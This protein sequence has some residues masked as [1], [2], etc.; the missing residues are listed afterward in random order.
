MTDADLL[1]RLFLNDMLDSVLDE[2][3]FELPEGQMRMVRDRD[4]ML[5]DFLE[6]SSKLGRALDRY[7][8]Q[9]YPAEL[10]ELRAERTHANG[11]DDGGSGRSQ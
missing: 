3:P 7:L 8:A 4:P 1:W 2:S 9:K 6:L 5:A 10:A 11:G